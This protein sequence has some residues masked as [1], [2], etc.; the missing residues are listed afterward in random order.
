MYMLRSLNHDTKIVRH[1]CI[2]LVILLA[3]DK[4]KVVRELIQH[5]RETTSEV[6]EQDIGESTRRRKLKLS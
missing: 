2:Y 6:S 3:T 1:A 5:V 4:A